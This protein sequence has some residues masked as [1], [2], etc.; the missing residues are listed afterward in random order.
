MEFHK[1][2]QK[3]I[4]HG[5]NATEFSIDGKKCKVQFFFDELLKKTHLLKN[6][7]GRIFFMGNGASAAF[8][9]HMALDWIKNGDVTAYS[10]SDSALLTALSNDY[11]YESAMVEYLKL[12]HCKSN[13]LVVTTSSSGNSEN[14]VN[15]LD[16]CKKNKIKT[17]AFSG[18]KKDNSSVKLGDFSL[19]IP[20]KT[21]GMVECIHQIYHHLWLDY[22]MGIEEWNKETEQNMDSKNYKL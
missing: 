8:S 22:F 4:N 6:D 20:L 16:Y 18:L 15:A 17:L 2:Y 9:N 14:I 1:N 3:A 12:N 13:D 5:M 10:L 21:Y 19:Y 7:N 11:S